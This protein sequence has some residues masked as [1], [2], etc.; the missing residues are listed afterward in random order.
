[1]SLLFSAKTSF[2][3]VTP[4]LSIMELIS[5]RILLVIDG[6]DFAR[7][8]LWLVALVGAALHLL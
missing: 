6:R 2:A 3:I 7:D 1:M 8:K 5:D 4:D